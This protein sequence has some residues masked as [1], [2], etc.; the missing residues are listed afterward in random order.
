MGFA[1]EGAVGQ[2]MSS[3]WIAGLRSSRAMRN[4]HDGD[5]SNWCTTPLRFALVLF[6]Y[7]ELGRECDRS[8]FRWP[9]QHKPHSQRFQAEAFL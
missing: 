4:S 9:P 7:A 8:K 6:R 5:V 2:C 1:E 3:S